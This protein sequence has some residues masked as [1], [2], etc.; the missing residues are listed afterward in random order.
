MATYIVWSTI[1]DLEGVRSEVTDAPDTKH[2]RTIFLDY[3]SRN[4]VIPYSQRGRVRASL[5]TYRTTPGEEDVAVHLDYNLTDRPVEVLTPESESP[6]EEEAE[7]APAGP[8]YMEPRRGFSVENI[9]GRSPIMDMARGVYRQGVE[10][11]S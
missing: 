4:K 8:E 3:L 7:G 11:G 9:Y 6:L 10:G 5:R 2:A 1:T